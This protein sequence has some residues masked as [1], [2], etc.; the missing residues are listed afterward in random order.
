MK[1]EMKKISLLL[2]FVC[3]MFATFAHSQTVESTQLQQ[4]KEKLVLEILMLDS[5][6]IGRLKQMDWLKQPSQ[7][8]LRVTAKQK[9]PHLTDEQ[10]KRVAE[11]QFQIHQ[12]ENE[13][14]DKEVLPKAF[15]I[16][17]TAYGEYFSY[18]ELKTLLDF[19]RSPTGK[20]L[21]FFDS[22]G[23]EKAMEPVMTDI[24]A[25]GRDTRESYLQIYFDLRKEGIRLQ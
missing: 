8:V 6:P 15:R 9:S 2:L 24:S 22:F 12:K 16:L 25:I 4:E 19:Y 3:A 23:L 1:L 10:V 18:S 13:R 11:L 21:I 17:S 14:F 7:E 5:S 20:K